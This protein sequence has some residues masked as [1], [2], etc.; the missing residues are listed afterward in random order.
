MRYYVGLV[1]VSLLLIQGCDLDELT[2]RG[3]YSDD[4]IEM[5][6]ILK[7][8]GPMAGRMMAKQ[9]CRKAVKANSVEELDLMIAMVHEIQTLKYENGYYH[10]I[11]IKEYIKLNIPPEYQGDVY[12]IVNLARRDTR[13]A[14]KNRDLE[15]IE[16]YMT[17][18]FKGVIQGLECAK[19]NLGKEIDPD[20]GGLMEYSLLT[21]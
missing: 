11:D 9:V 14:R 6:L 8:K 12:L 15:S 16:S 1:L 10:W 20:R 5:S 19:K 13:W 4:P 7:T 21:H 17:H 18:V 2:T 3:E